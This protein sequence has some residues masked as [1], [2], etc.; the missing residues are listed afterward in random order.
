MLTATHHQIPSLGIYPGIHPAY[1]LGIFYP[2]DLAVKSGE[3][4]NLLH[5]NFMLFSSYY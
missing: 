4:H 3:L 2:T 5:K 1:C